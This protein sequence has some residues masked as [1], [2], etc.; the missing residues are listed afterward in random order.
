MGRG[1]INKRRVSYKGKGSL[2]REVGLIREG[3]VNKGKRSLIR[4]VGINKGASPNSHRKFGFQCQPPIVP[5]PIS[6]SAKLKN[7]QC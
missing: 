6:F 2:I 3:G 4:E 7:F 1:L 5:I